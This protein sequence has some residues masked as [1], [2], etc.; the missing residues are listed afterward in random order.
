MI[1]KIFFLVIFTNYIVHVVL[2]D[3]KSQDIKAK[4]PI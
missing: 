1:K 4:T 3:N 2:D